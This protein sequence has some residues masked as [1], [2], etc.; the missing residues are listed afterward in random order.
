MLEALRQEQWG[1]AKHTASKDE[2]GDNIELE[3]KVDS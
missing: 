1:R 2:G 3:G